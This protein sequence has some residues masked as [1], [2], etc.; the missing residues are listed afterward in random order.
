[1]M[2][3]RGALSLHQ[4]TKR[5]AAAAAVAAAV[6]S[7]ASAEPPPPPLSAGKRTVGDKVRGDGINLL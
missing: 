1:V 3:G 7:S 5:A 4:E 6:T 2:A